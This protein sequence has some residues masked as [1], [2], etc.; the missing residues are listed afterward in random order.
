MGDGSPTFFGIGDAAG[1]LAG[2][3]RV[4]SEYGVSSRTRTVMRS[5]VP[6]V[7]VGMTEIVPWNSAPLYCASMRAP[8]GCGPRGLAPP[9]RPFPSST[10]SRDPSRSNSTPV[11]YQPTGIHPCTT[12]RPGSEML[13]SVTVLLSA[14][15][16]SSVL[17]SGEI[18]SAFGVEPTGA[19][20]PRAT[21]ICSAGMLRARSTTQTALVLAQATNRREPSEVTAIALG[22]SPTAISPFCTSVQ[23]SSMTIFDPP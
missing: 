13:A 7:G 20:T 22:C 3:S 1:T 12:L 6:A 18:E 19:C 2:A 15:A 8:P 9:A 16:T 5:S 17:P 23:G 21:E 4:A 14:L 11:G 10:N